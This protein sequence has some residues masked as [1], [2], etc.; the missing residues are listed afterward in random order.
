MDLRTAEYLVRIDLDARHRAANQRRLVAS[1]DRTPPGR[2][3]LRPIGLGLIALG[4]LLEGSPPDP[5]AE[6]SLAR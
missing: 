1:L 5:L 3:M 2:G 4:R 6:P